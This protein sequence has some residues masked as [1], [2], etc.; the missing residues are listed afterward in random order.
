[1]DLQERKKVILKAQYE[2]SLEAIGLIKQYLQ[3]VFEEIGVDKDTIERL[4]KYK[5]M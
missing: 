4:S 2:K 3:E 1:M 5:I